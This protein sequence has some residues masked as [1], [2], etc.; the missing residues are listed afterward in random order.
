MDIIEHFIR[1]DFQVIHNVPME[2]IQ[3][4]FHV[5]LNKCEFYFSRLHVNKIYNFCF[6]L[7]NGCVPGMTKMD[8]YAI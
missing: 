7:H 5:Y 4:V 2:P 6:L 8:K 3:E 1:L